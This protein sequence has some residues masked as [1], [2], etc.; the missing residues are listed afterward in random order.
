MNKLEKANMWEV[1][2][3]RMHIKKGIVPLST[4]IIP[5][6]KDL[7]VL[8]HRSLGHALTP[9]ALLFTLGYSEDDMSIKA[10][11]LYFHH[12]LIARQL[13][14]DAHDW[15]ED[16]R[17]GHINAVG[18]LVL[19]A[20]DI[21]IDMLLSRLLPMLQKQFWHQDIQTVCVLIKKHVMLAKRAIRKCEAISD[22]SMFDEL[23]EKY[24]RASDTALEERAH[25]IG[26]LKRYH[27]SIRKVRNTRVI[28]LK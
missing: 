2:Y 15:S 4:F 26:F 21:R 10:M 5:D 8:A 24:N 16:L 6:Y 1:T 3:A 20:A 13:N 28:H 22:F 11:R 7:H 17:R 27:G 25:M 12:F 19:K 23:V 14:D 9:L 18:A